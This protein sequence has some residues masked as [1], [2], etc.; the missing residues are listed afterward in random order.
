MLL[1]LAL[2]TLGL[3]PGRLPLARTALTATPAIRLQLARLDMEG[4]NVE[5]TPALREA[6]EA[7]LGKALGRYE[8]MLQSTSLRFKV[9]FRGGGKHDTTHK[10]QEAH[11]AE[12]TALCKD[13]QVIRVTSESTDMYASLDILED[14]FARR[15]RKH[16]EKKADKR[17]EG[18]AEAAAVIADDAIGDVDEPEPPPAM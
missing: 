3:Q 1:S 16:K 15:L 14:K 5:V 7:K 13:K 10:G 6:A 8:P 9:E 11:V 18:H 4:T 17:G 12:I 2:S